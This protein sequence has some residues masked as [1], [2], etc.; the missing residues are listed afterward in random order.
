MEKI[1]L[2]FWMSL[3]LKDIVVEGCFWGTLTYSRKIAQFKP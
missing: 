2:K 3:E 1:P